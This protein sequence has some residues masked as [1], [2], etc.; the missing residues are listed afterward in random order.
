MCSS[1]LFQ[2]E[3]VE[4]NFNNEQTKLSANE[5]K[6]NSFFKSVNELGLITVNNESLLILN[7]EEASLNESF[8]DKK[9]ISKYRGQSIFDASD[10]KL[11]SFNI[12]EFNLISNYNF[13]TVINESV[14]FANDISVIQNMLLNYNNK[15]LII[16]NP[17]FL[18]F[19]KSIPEKTTYF[20]ILNLGDSNETIDYPYWFTNYEIGRAHV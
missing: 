12:M 14:I 15:S 17:S 8:N 6:L 10:I 2:S 3:T 5:K 20:E 7:F 9:L 19:L 16:N 13:F 4:N 1:D 11:S 18:N